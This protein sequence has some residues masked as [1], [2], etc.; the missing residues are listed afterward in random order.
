MEKEHETVSLETQ[1][2]ALSL[3]HKLCP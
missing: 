2:C 3:Y 1:K